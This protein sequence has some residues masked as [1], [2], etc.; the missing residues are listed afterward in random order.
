MSYVSKAIAYIKEGYYTLY[1]IVKGHWV[2]L[3][4]LVRPKVTLQYPE[5]R[6]ELPPGYRGFPGLPVDSET[7]RDACIGCGACARTCPT[8][9]IVIET[10]VGE[11]KKR[12]VD[13]FTMN[14]GR[15]MFCGMCAEACPV[16]AIVM[17]D[18]FELAAFTRDEIIFE[19]KKLNEFGG[20]KE[21]K[22]KSEPGSGGEGA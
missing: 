16:D 8:Q 2:T 17:T 3:I 12:V 22:P 15:C 9:V 18:N 19:R 20:T 21:P 4:N 13:S 10:H 6:W 5:V 14:A 1:S 11:D 7:G